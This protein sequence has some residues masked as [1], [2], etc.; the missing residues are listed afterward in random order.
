MVLFS[1]ECS[2]CAFLAP[3]ILVNR[4]LN[5]SMEEFRNCVEI[6]TYDTSGHTKLPVQTVHVE[7]GM[8]LG[9][10]GLVRAKLDM[11]Y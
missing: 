11:L 2:F 4:A 9:W 5:S 6:Y 1:I 7:V 3:K 10:G 8:G